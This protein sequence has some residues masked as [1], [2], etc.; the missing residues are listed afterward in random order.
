MTPDIVVDVGNSRVKWG[1]CHAGAISETACFP[2]ADLPG[3]HQQLDS[4]KI[5]GVCRWVISG[6]HPAALEQLADWI[7]RRGDA[8]VV[9]DKAQSLP[10]QVRLEHPDRVGIDRLLNAVA[11]TSRRRTSAPAVIIDAGS[12]VTVDYVDETGAFCGGAICPGVRLMIHALHTYTALLPLVEVHQPI[13][14]LPGIS[15]PEAMQAGVYWTVA[16]GIQTLVS[17]QITAAP[18]EAEVF[19]TGGDAL[20]LKPAL[21]DSVTLWPTMTLE[22]VRLAAEALP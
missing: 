3:W 19:L 11:A 2:H 1:R 18:G 5:A 21:A 13:P 9:L 8:L 17:R 15:T 10:L 22:G 12:A 7:R 6:V 16:G 4:W 20:L 14:P